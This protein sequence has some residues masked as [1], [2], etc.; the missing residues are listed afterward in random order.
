[1]IDIKNGH[2]VDSSGRV[3][4]LRGVNL[5]GSAKVPTTPD[6]A[7]WIKDS[8]ANHRDVSFIGRPLPLDE[9]DEHFARLRAWGFTTIR[10]VITWEAVEHA[11]PG[12][13]DT[14]YLSCLRELVKKADGY[15]ML[16]IIDPHQ[17]VWSRFTGGDGAPGWTLEQAGF[18]L[19]HL[20]DCGA[21][22][23]HQHHGDP[24]PRMIWPSNYNK[25]AAA[26]MFTLF[27]AGGDFAPNCMIAGVNIQDYLQQHYIGAVTQVAQAL[28]DLPNI[29]GF[30][31]MNEPSR[32]YIGEPD[33]K[34]IP[35][36]IEVRLG[37]TPT[38]L[39]SMALGAGTPQTVAVYKLG[40]TGFRKVGKSLAN[41]KGISAWQ[42]PEKDIWRE[43]GLWQLNKLGQPEVIMPDYFSVV[44]GR[45]V[46]F[47]NDYYKPFIR[48][49]SQSVREIMPD[50]LLF[51]ETVP[52]DTNLTWTKD[53]PHNI[54]YADHWYDGITL[55]FK[56][57]REW[58]AAD[59]EKLRLSL[60]K[61]QAK[62]SFINQINR[63]KQRAKTNFRNTP[64]LVGETGIPFDLSKKQAYRTG[65][66]NEQIKALD[67]TM[68]AMEQNLVS[69]TLWNYTADNSNAHGD[70]WNDEDFSLYSPDQKTGT[71]SL[72][73]GGRA[74]R[75][76]VRPYAMKTAGT[77]LSQS[78]NIKTRRYHF[79]FEADP[80]ISEPTEIFVPAYQYP[81]GI[82]VSVSDGR[83]QY[84]PEQQLLLY[85]AFETTELHQLTIT[86][87]RAQ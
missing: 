66:F 62:R 8:L 79:T 29:V 1:M 53:D 73:D 55:S 22:L 7:T 36:A 27:F 20:D 28:H 56:Q 42:L 12:I 81:D 23:T 17:D 70:L 58:L 16:V 41:A 64:V 31:P 15:G 82:L 10:L 74:L 46:N 38:I 32:G 52:S 6:G 4:S 3:L 85:F 51:I 39:Q 40:L 24:L 59:A 35:G 30:E 67:A 72:D 65:D 33:L 44:N 11:G 21:A 54:I 68:S 14:A 19:D 37:Q 2:F 86:P 83:Y 69:F 75:A 43:H 47:N 45:Q 84:L 63:F 18:D 5:S 49:L 71:G 9:A 48:K 26:T 25:L 77:P 34:R 60:G 13:Y 57:F 80:A 76:A 61:K 50:T 87:I 78:F